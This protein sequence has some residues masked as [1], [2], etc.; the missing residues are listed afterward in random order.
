MDTLFRIYEPF[1]CGPDGYPRVWHDGVIGI[2]GKWQAGEIRIEGQPRIRVGVKDAVRHLAGHRCE[3]CHHPYKLGTGEW[4]VDELNPE[5]PPSGL[6]SLMERGE[7]LGVEHQ[8]KTRPPLWSA[9]DERCEHKG[10]CRI[11]DL[12]RREAGPTWDAL[13]P[14]FV[15]TGAETA[16]D[17]LRGFVAGTTEVQAAWRILTVHHLNGRKEDLRWHNLVA[18]CQR[19]HLT[20]QRKVVMEQVFPYEHS[21]WFR[22]YAAAFYAYSYLGLELSREET[23]GRLGELLALERAA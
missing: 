6:L 10:P 19:C 13:P 23:M 17:V 7:S 14:G 21:E 11:V 4:G 12:E 3:R 5:G 16:G 8:M 18:L 20:I 9:C 15:R 22:P 2:K 1:E